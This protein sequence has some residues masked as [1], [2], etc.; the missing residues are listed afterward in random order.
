M[1]LYGLRNELSL[2]VNTLNHTLIP[3]FDH[4][5][6]MKQLNLLFRPYIFGID[7]NKLR[8]GELRWG[9]SIF[10]VFMSHELIVVKL[11]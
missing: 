6:F 3:I 4:D 7:R 8:L 9:S 1:F 11:L 2:T 10:G 5:L